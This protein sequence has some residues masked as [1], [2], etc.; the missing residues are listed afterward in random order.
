MDRHLFPGSNTSRGF[1]GFFEDIRKNAV[2]TVILK[3]GPGVGKSTLMNDVGKR[4]AEKGYTVTYFHCSGDPD[5]LDAVSVRENGFVILDGTAPHVLDPRLPGAADGI[6]NLGICLNEKQLQKQ[7]SEIEAISQRIAGHYAACT[8]YLRGA[9]EMRE[10]ARAVYA[11]AYPEKSRR[12]TEDALFSHFPSAPEGEEISAFAQAITW[13]G[14]LQ[15][16]DSVIGEEAV[17]LDMPWGFDCDLLLRPL[18]NAAQRARA[19]TVLYRDPLEPDKLSHI[20][21][22]QTVFTTAVLLDAPAY[23]P[24]LD[25]SRLARESARLSYDRAVYDLLLNQAVEHLAEAKRGHDEMERYYIDAMDYGRL[26]AVRQEFLEEL[27][28]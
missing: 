8:R 16:M 10:D 2:R 13:K 5:S 19:R 9:R 11:G 14:V 7:R 15:Q 28:E 3:G 26:N 20:Q 22:G 24:A 27:P 17:C 4:Y 23:A 21:I 6:L 12:D 25:Q 1:V 18:W